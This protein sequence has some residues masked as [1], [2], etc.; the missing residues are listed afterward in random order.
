MTV[1]TGPPESGTVTRLEA[2]DDLAGRPLVAVAALLWV[3]PPVGPL[4][5]SN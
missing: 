3:I 1:L 2:H 4:H 5:A